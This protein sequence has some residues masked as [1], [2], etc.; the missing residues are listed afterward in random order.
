VGRTHPRWRIW[1]QNRVRA[2]RLGKMQ[3]ALRIVGYDIGVVEG[4]R[5][6][7]KEAAE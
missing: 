2:P 7:D 3:A 1:A 5:H 6:P 4:R